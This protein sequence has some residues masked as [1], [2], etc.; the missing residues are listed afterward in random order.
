[1]KFFQGRTYLI[2]FF[3][4]TNFQL[5]HISTMQKFRGV[6]SLR[7]SP[8]P[9]SLQTT[10][11]CKI[12]LFDDVLHTSLFSLENDHNSQQIISLKDIIEQYYVV[13]ILL[14]TSVCTHK[15]VRNSS[16]SWR[17]SVSSQQQGSIISPHTIALSCFIV[18]PF[19]IIKQQHSAMLR[20]REKCQEL[21]VLL[22]CC[23]PGRL[24]SVL[25]K[26]KKIAMTIVFF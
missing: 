9:P 3:E 12:I 11:K 19:S 10:V 26:W 15:M 13:Y 17:S 24:H 21:L 14:Y 25:W 16:S 22:L 7:F 1:M 18:C 23:W 5:N 8:V 2:K 6:T 4:I 20:R